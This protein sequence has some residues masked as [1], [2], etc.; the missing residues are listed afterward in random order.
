MAHFL[1]SQIDDDTDDETSEDEDSDSDTSDSDS[2][3][4][5][6]SNYDFW[7]AAT[8]TKHFKSFNSHMLF[9]EAISCHGSNFCINNKPGENDSIQIYEYGYHTS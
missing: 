9:S 5:V 2:D 3:W 8:I 4:H 7:V 6:T 1:F